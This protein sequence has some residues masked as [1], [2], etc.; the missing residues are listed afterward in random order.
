MRTLVDGD[1][2]VHKSVSA[3][4]LLDVTAIANEFSNTAVLTGV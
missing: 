3:D 1:V 4:D 2:R